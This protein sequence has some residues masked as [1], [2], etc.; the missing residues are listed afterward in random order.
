M[1]LLALIAAEPTLLPL[2][3]VLMFAAGM[4]PVGMLFSCTP[5]CNPCTL[6]TEGSLP[7]TVTVTLSGLP[8]EAQHPLDCRLTFAACYG[9]GAEGTWTGPGEDDPGPMTGV[10][11]T[12]G[13]GGYAKFGRVAPTLTPSA[14][15]GTGATFAVTLQAAEDSCGLDYWRVKSVTASGGTGYVDGEPVTITIATG[16]TVE[17]DAI[18]TL[19]TAREEPNL[20]ASVG[21]PGTGADLEVVLA[22]NAGT[23][24]TWRVDSVTVTDGGTGYTDGQEVTISLSSGDQ[25]ES[26]AYATIRTGRV[27]PA[28]ASSIASELGTGG[29]L[30]FTLRQETDQDGRS[31]WQI[32]TVSVVSGGS[33]YAVYDY[34]EF[35]ST[36]GSVDLTPYGYVAS[37]DQDGAITSVAIDNAGVFYKSTDVIESVFVEDGGRYYRP[38]DVAARASVDHGGVYYREDASLPPYVATVDVDVIQE[39]PSDGTGAVISAVVEDD[40]QSPDFGKIV[41]LSLDDGGDGYVAWRYKKVCCG[42]YNGMTVVLRRGVTPR[43]SSGFSSCEYGHRFCGSYSVFDYQG[44]LSVTYHGPNTPPTVFLA[45]EYNVAENT[46]RQ[47]RMCDTTFTASEPITNCSNMSF[48]ATAPNGAVATVVAG[49]DYDAEYRATGNCHPCSQGLCEIDEEVEATILAEAGGVVPGLPDGVYVLSRGEIRTSEVRLVYW[50]YGNALISIGYEPC[51]VCEE[52]PGQPCTGLKPRDEGLPATCNS[53]RF[54]P[55]ITSQLGPF[56]QLAQGFFSDECRP[57]PVCSPAGETWTL[58]RFG[59]VYPGAADSVTLTT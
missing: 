26:L 30:G 13:G 6:C 47:A 56:Y 22:Q 37:V 17:F 9:S 34:V 51:A 7:D 44:Y 55:S 45:A 27:A 49:G 11:L 39:L 28:M 21:A 50:M 1:D 43:G 15:N 16:D 10:T 41:S 32:D 58:V 35:Y 57:T 42:Y 33:D 54:L 25:Y 5:C 59:P 46:S 19:E 23:P 18:V 4:Y 3:A 12:N 29:E 14:A 40:T 36:D 20:S 31:Y 52:P 48:T 24:E 38:G 53:C 8:D 2:W